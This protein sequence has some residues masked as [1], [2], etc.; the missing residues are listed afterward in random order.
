MNTAYAK[1]IPAR[2]GN[3]DNDYWQAT[4]NTC[5]WKGALSSNRTTEGKRLAQRDADDHN[6]AVHS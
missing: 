5:P 6:Q 3:R 2:S 4:C 1:R